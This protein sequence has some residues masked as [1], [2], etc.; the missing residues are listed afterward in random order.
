[1]AGPVQKAA[2]TIE[3]GETLSC[4]FNPKDY[5]VTKA[6]SWEA[7]AAPGKSAAKPTF[8]GG[9]P[10]ELTLQLLFDATLLTPQMSVKD[11]GAKLFGAMNASKNEG[12][13][14]NKSRPPTL[15]FTW[16]AFSFQG[17]AKNLTVQYQLFRPDGEPIRADVKLALMQWDVEGPAGQNPTTR[18]DGA[19]G[20]HVVRDGDSLASIAYRAYGDPTHWRLIA[21]ANGID[22]PL[23]LRS[24]RALSIPGIDG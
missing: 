13:T 5:S 21:E 20:A 8:G 15:T 4:L 24:G 17:V 3:D 6:N 14:K 11:V 18:S 7:K 22:D 1:M 9:Q 10:R 23:R 19:L 12:G 2:L 16:G